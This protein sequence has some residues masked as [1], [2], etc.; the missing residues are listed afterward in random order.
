MSG[1]SYTRICCCA[2]CGKN[3]EYILKYRK[4][5]F[6]RSKFNYCKSCLLKRRKELEEEFSKK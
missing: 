5:I 1:Y 6:L 2:S 3:A 4:G